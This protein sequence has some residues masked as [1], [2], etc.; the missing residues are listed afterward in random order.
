MPGLLRV[1]SSTGRVQGAVL[2]LQPSGTTLNA[3][4][5]DGAGRL[6]VTTSADLR[7]LS[8]I[9]PADQDVRATWRNR[10]PPVAV[11]AS[12]TS[13]LAFA[14]I[15]T[16]GGDRV[17]QIALSGKRSTVVVTSLGGIGQSLAAG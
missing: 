5:V 1:D 11:A 10:V 7:T 9:H 2:S 14:L 17:E 13:P 6:V 4:S 3:V 15:P 12:T 16:L 8:V